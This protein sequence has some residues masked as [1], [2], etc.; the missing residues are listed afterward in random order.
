M[1]HEP[2]QLSITCGHAGKAPV[3]L[4]VRHGPSKVNQLLLWNTKTDEITPGQ[5]FKG[6]LGNWQLSPDG[7]Y[8]LYH[9]VKY[10][11][12]EHGRWMAISRPPYLTALALWY[13]EH[14]TAGYWLDDRHIAAPWSGKPDVGKLRPAIKLVPI[15]KVGWESCWYERDWPPIPGGWKI[16]HEEIEEHPQ[17]LIRRSRRYLEHSESNQKHEITC[18]NLFRDIRGRIVMVRDGCL[19]AGTAEEILNDSGKLVYDFRPNEFEEVV[20]PEWATRW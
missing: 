8:L 16:V 12:K 11:V 3:A 17:P 15:Q 20:A 6:S 1:E 10:W 14:A 7:R 13:V 19:Y 9:A 18:T 2:Y 4:I 5:W